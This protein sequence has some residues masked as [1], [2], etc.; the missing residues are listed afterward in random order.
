M[1]KSSYQKY[2]DARNKNLAR[3]H[4]RSSAEE[5]AREYSKRNNVIC[6]VVN[7][8]SDLG[9]YTP[10]KLGAYF[11]KAFRRKH[12]PSHIVTDLSS[13]RNTS[14]DFYFGGK[15]MLDRP[16]SPA[17]AA[18]QIDDLIVEVKLF[19]STYEN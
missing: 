8:G 15:P 18:T 17:M 1:K 10:E 14:I 3:A 16:L 13:A 2:F 11:Q 19:A 6:I 12:V 9:E 4:S 5:K 7:G